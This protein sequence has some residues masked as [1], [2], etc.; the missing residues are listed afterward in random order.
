MPIF[1]V[2]DFRVQ[3]MDGGTIVRVDGLG[4]EHAPTNLNH[5]RA[6]LMLAV[7]NDG[8]DCYWDQGAERFVTTPVRH[9]L[10]ES[11]INRGRV[12]LWDVQIPAT[13][14]VEFFIAL[15][16]DDQKEL[17][18]GDPAVGWVRLSVR[19]D[20][21][22]LVHAVLSSAYCYYLNGTLRNTDITS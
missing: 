6:A 20:V 8:R 2:M 4:Q 12:S 13:G 9:E 3:Y 15:I 19:D 18:S 7:F 5:A 17:T 16:S 22:H 10:D 11:P 21:A 14:D 1:R